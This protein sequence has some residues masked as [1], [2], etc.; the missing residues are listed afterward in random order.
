MKSSQLTI[1]G[2]HYN[3]THFTIGLSLAISSSVFIGA[4][5]IIKKVALRKLQASGNVRA[6]AGGFAYL[7]QWLWWLGFITMGIGE[8]ANLLAYAFAPAALV[9]P[10]GALSVL[11][12]AVL[13]SR[14]LKEKL[15]FIGKI[16][17][18]LC[19]IGSVIFVIHSPKSE[20]ITTFSELVEKLIDYLFLSYVGTI[21]LMGLIIKLVFIPRFGNTNVMVYL[22][23][24]SSTGSLTV[25]FCKGVALGVRESFSGNVNNFTNYIFWLLFITA[26]F[27]IMIQM[28]YLNKSLDIFNTSVVTPVY[29]VMFTLLVIIASG[30]LFKE[31]DH[32]NIPDIVGCV[33]GF[34]IVITAVFM[35]NA[36]KDV[37]IAFKDL[38]LNARHRRSALNLHVEERGP[39]N[40]AL[41]S[42]MR[43]L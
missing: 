9:T 20:E 23:L 36:F 13:S 22:L 35:L 21:L 43:H 33:C 37:K 7:K 4:S 26:V 40:Y 31:W 15:N 18:F 8:A 19:V 11:V 32:M 6:S 1:N 39:E 34:L 30:I 14:F 42:R 16:G 10:L 29:Y 25:V 24:C 5:F 27:C 17:C 41:S 2:Q 38:N 12:A 3:N 28:N